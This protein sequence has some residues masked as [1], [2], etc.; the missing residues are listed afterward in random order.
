M[1]KN[2]EGDL[3]GNYQRFLK[4]G[5]RFLYE[6]AF[7]S[8][9]D[10][11]AWKEHVSPPIQHRGKSSIVPLRGSPSQP[12]AIT[13]SPFSRPTVNQGVCVQPFL[14]TNVLASQWDR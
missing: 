5:I 10:L 1:C 2:K 13:S 3:R 14:L 8:C 12:P 4:N 7:T 9:M 6:Q 11:Q